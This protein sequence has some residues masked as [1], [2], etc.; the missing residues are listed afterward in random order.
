MPIPLSLLISRAIER[1]LE[2]KVAI[3][4]SGGLD[5]AI[6]ATVAKRH[7]I[8]ELFTAGA[9]GCDD[10][11]SAREAALSLSLPL[12]EVMLDEKGIME[13]YGKCHS[14]LKLDLLKTEILVPV[15]AVAHAA[16]KKGHRVMLFGSG[17]EEL[18][19]GYK[20]YFDYRSEGKD[21]DAIL[22]EEYK[23]LS[24]RDISYVKRVCRDAGIEARF[25][26]YDRELSEAVFAIPLEER[27][28][29]QN[30]KK[31]VL[32]EAGRMLGAPE[33]ALKRKKKAMQ[34][35]AGVHKIIMNHADEI[36]RN[37]PPAKNEQ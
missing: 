24:Q 15:Y 16:A 37:Y 5:S 12:C 2:D 4:F 3:A 26:F 25:P 17:A 7:S 29:D 11:P 23:T 10:I 36:N 27:M 22:K 33:S 6:I 30:L 1:T 18:F 9:A 21:L 19:V 31:T 20:K 28:H 32:R 35:G 13:A 8:V 14:M 34:Y